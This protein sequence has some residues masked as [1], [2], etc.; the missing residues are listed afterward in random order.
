MQVLDTRMEHHA[1]ADFSCASDVHI[2]IVHTTLCSSSSEHHSHLNGVERMPE[3]L[4]MMKQIREARRSYFIFHL[5][6]NKQHFF[7]EKP[8]VGPWY[9]YVVHAFPFSAIRDSNPCLT[10]FSILKT[11][12]ASSAWFERARHAV[13]TVPT[14]CACNKP[15]AFTCWWPQSSVCW[16]FFCWS[17]ITSCT[18]GLCAGHPSDLNE[19][20]LCSSQTVCI[21][22]V[23]AHVH[24][25]GDPLQTIR[26]LP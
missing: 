5:D 19:W 18:L 8:G 2:C 21:R 26:R 12:S 7:S 20:L 6:S 1:Y 16:Y 13:W 22:Q 3:T 25:Q 10:R 17:E 15:C 14:R 4:T 9:A 23:I 24:P 11:T